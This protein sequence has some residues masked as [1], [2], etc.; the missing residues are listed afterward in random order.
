MT[1]ASRVEEFWRSMRDDN[2]GT[3][4]AAADLTC[5]LEDEP[6]PSVKK[7]KK[8]YKKKKKFV[9]PVVV[10]EVKPSIESDP[11]IEAEEIPHE[12]TL[13]E[14][15]TP[16]QADPEPEAVEEPTCNDAQHTRVADDTN[17]EA[18][19]PK[20]LVYLPF[21]AQHR[22]IVFLQHKLEEMC[23]SYSE[24]HL[25]QLL[26]DR[27]WDCPEALEL[28]RWLRTLS[29][30]LPY[31]GQDW[32]FNHSILFD[33]VAQIRNFAVT[34]SK[35]DSAQMEKL[36]TDAFE[37]ATILNE[38]KTI[39]VIL[40]LRQDMVHTSKYLGSET[41]Q[42]K[43]TFDRKLGEIEAAR[44]KLNELENATKTALKKSLMGRQEHARSKIMQSIQKA[45]A[46][47]QIPDSG[48]RSGAM[49]SL[50]L[51]NDLENSLM[52]DDEGQDHV[53]PS[54]SSWFAC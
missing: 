43:Q 49:S 30:E 8:I 42:I 10:E 53:S 17:E 39:K 51:V 15:D 32:V 44:T 9:E 33:S 1:E 27:G 14:C 21:S 2:N 54:R 20:P 36:M 22:L 46:I 47:D 40:R 11:I 12:P 34:R 26:H 16:T 23:Y 29:V 3:P 13:T 37:L 6:K 35:I 38:E 52:L 18:E 25:P 45:E 28:H 4:V 41:E 7:V 24:R 5:L 31:V 48:N 19:D 50:D